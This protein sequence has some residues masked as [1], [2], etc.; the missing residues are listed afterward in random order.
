MIRLEEMYQYQMV[1]CGY[2]NN[3]ER[4]D[5]KGK[6]PAGTLLAELSEDWHCPCCG[7]GPKRFR[8]LAQGGG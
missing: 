7:A 6:I 3:P 2:I 1:N 8:R 4:G 5:K